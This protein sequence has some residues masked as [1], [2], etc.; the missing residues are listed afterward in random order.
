MRFHNAAVDAARAGEPGG[1]FAQVA[2]GVRNLAMRAADAAK[3]TAGENRRS[4]GRTKHGSELVE[5]TDK[6]CRQLAE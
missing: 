3:N 4:V 2:G 6:K 5:K 1:G